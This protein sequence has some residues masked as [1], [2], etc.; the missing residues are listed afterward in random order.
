MQG[1]IVQRVTRTEAQVR[2]YFDE[3]VKAYYMFSQRGTV[4]PTVDSILNAANVVNNVAQTFGS[5]TSDFDAYVTLELTGLSS[6]SFYDVYVIGVDQSNNVSAEVE[7]LSFKT[8]RRHRPVSLTIFT[9]VI[10]DAE[11][12]RVAV[13]HALAI[14]ESWLW[15][16][17]VD[18]SLLGP[19]RRLQSSYGYDFTLVVPDDDDHELSPYDL[20]RL[21]DAR[22]D[23]LQHELPTLDINRLITDTVQEYVGTNPEFTQGPDVI[24]LGKDFA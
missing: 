2:L 23:V 6:S 15:Y 21:L 8:P 4:Q 10:T 14:P 7:T 13:C 24:G 20:A 12:V 3:I 9:V 5:A 1:K 16:T 18:P 22:R 11:I 19:G 17:G